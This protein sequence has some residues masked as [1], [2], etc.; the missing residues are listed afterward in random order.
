MFILFAD[1]SVKKSRRQTSTLSTVRLACLETLPQRHQWAL[2][3]V[4][5]NSL[6][7]LKDFSEDVELIMELREYKSYAVFLNPWCRSPVRAIF[8]RIKIS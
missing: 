7:N 2:C 3:V 8:T 6:S 4:R 1:R 5:N